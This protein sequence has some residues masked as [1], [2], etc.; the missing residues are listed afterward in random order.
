MLFENYKYTRDDIFERLKA[1][2]IVARKYF[3]PLTSDFECYRNLS[4][5][6]GDKTPV[7][8]HIAVNILTLPIYSD[9]DLDVV[10]KICDIIKK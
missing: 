8:K 7:A 2:G 4:Y 3:F 5:G 10:E 6:G 9:L 1:D